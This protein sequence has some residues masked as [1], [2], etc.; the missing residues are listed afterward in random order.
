[1]AVARPVRCSGAATCMSR[2]VA[3]KVRAVQSLK[4][5]NSP[6][7]KLEQE[8]AVYSSRTIKPRHSRHQHSR[9]RHHPNTPQEH[10]F[11]IHQQGAREHHSKQV[12][13]NLKKKKS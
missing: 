7:D 5:F 6:N 3:C 4:L 2:T 12:D 11:Q 10:I 8:I 13:Y 9:S 1:M